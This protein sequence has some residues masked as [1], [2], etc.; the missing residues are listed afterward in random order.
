MPS[1]S[2]D[3]GP[4]TAGPGPELLGTRLRLLLSLLEADVA[5]VHDGLGLEGMRPRYVPVL[6]TLAAEGPSSIQDLAGAT[7]VTHSAASQTVA[8]LVQEGL[9]TVGPGSDGRRRI[10]SLTAKAEALLPAL[11]AEWQA[12]AAAATALEAELAYPLSELVGEALAALQQR[13][14]LQRISDAAPDLIRRRT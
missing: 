1:T 2:T 3:P 11:D 14:M 9:A 4:H 10:A 8:Q 7:G 6:R 5:T 12:T 13:S